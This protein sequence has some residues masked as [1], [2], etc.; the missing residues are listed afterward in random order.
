MKHIV[1]YCVNLSLEVESQF[2]KE[3]KS[4]VPE[5]PHTLQ[6]TTIQVDSDFLS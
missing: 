6:N 2:G 1:F 3:I 4:K 5:K